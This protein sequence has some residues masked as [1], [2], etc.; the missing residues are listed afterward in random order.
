MTVFLE[1]THMEY[2]CDDRSRDWS[3]VTRT[4]QGVPGR[5]VTM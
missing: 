2:D 3:G 5:A 1:K 4:S